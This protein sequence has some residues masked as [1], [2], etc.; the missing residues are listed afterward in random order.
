MFYRIANRTIDTVDGGDVLRLRVQF[1]A[2][3]ASFDAGD[4]AYENVFYIHH[5][6][7]PETKRQYVM[8]GDN[9]VL[10][11]GGTITPRDYANA[12]EA[13]N[14]FNPRSTPPPELATEEVAFDVGGFL[15][16]YLN[17]WW[18]RTAGN[19]PARAEDPTQVRSSNN[20]RGFISRTDIQGLRD[21]TSPRTGG[22]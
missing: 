11:S 13:Y 12:V 18:A 2:D 10:A 17:G 4:P 9:Y 14:P 16:D 22:R 20:R 21:R 15:D 8:Q 6:I 3:G 5:V 19:R 7:L 1:W